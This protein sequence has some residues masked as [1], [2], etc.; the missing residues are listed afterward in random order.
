M[1]CKWE[2]YRSLGTPAVKPRD[3]RTCEKCQR[4]MRALLVTLSCNHCDSK[5]KGTFYVGYIVRL[6]DDPRVVSYY[7]WPTIKDAQDWSGVRDDKI[8]A[9]LSPT[10][11]HWTATHG[12][13]TGLVVA[14]DPVTVHKDHR[15]APRPNHAFLAPEGFTPSGIIANLR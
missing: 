14:K 6:D 5:A 9:I 15:F 1:S 3:T 8:F 2:S 7:V 13:P 10:P 4:P 11:F 12:G